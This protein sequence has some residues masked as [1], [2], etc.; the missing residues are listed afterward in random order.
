MRISDQKLKNSL[1]RVND[2]I[3][4]LNRNHRGWSCQDL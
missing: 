3:E 4:G 1:M 2:S